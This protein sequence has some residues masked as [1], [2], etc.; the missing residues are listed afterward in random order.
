MPLFLKAHRAP[1]ALLAA[2]VLSGLAW[3][4]TGT[5][6][7]LPQLLAGRMQPVAVALLL[8]AAIA[9]VVAYAFGGEGLRL[10]STARRSLWGQDLALAGLVA[11]PVLV[12]TVLSAATAGPPSAV[13]FARDAA[14]FGGLA[15][16]ALTL[17]G[18]S[19]AVTVPLGY[20]LLTVTLGGQPDGGSH[21]W[22]AIRGPASATTG[23][24]AGFLLVAGIV[25]FSACARR[26]RSVSAD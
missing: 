4:F 3:L 13:V 15:L 1:R 23:L 5:V 12:G 20:F 6:L 17:L 26:R 9:P 18:E 16:I 19:A 24:T 22:A 11:L 25:L 8:G 14:A 7:E 2:A 10:E 21:W